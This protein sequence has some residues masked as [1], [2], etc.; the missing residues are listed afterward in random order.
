MLTNLVIISLIYTILHIV[1][2]DF[3]D[4]YNTVRGERLLPTDSFP[5]ADDKE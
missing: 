4:C 2:S 1:L 3:R 5:G